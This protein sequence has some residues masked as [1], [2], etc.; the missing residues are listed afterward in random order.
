VVAETHA[1]AAPWAA[2]L[3][4]TSSSAAAAVA[5]PVRATL[6]VSAQQPEA[7]GRDGTTADT[8]AGYLAAFALAAGAIGIVYHPVRVAA[9]AIVLALVAAGMAGERHARL[10]F[11][12]VVGTSA[13]WVLGMIFAVITKNPLW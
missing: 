13:F 9:P 12:A 2:R 4:G 7:V 3:A 1:P 11:A 5:A 8:V 10:A 6:Q